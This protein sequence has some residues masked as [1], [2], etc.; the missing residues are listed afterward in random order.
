MTFDAEDMALTDRLRQKYA[1]MVVDR[2]QEERLGQGVDTAAIAAAQ[3]RE[4]QKRL[5]EMKNSRGGAAAVNE[6]AQVKLCQYCQG[7]GR[8]KE[9]Y[10]Y[11]EM[12]RHCEHCDGEGTISRGGPKPK[13]EQP[14]PQT[15]EINANKRYTLQKSIRKL[16]SQLDR[17]R[18]EMDEV[19]AKMHS[20]EVSNQ[21]ERACLEELTNQLQAHMDGLRDRLADKKQALDKL[22]ALGTA[23]A[24]D[25]AADS[26]ADSSI[27][28]GSMHTAASNGAAANGA[29][30]G[31]MVEEVV[32]EPRAATR[33]DPA[34]RPSVAD[35]PTAPATEVKAEEAPQAPVAAE[36]PR[37]AQAE[38]GGALAGLPILAQV[39]DVSLNDLD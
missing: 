32:E 27:L 36:E 37:A 33:D 1:G 13:P 34:G 31:P 4:D 17:Y 30:R 24:P 3:R 25:P 14:K 7:A 16:E 11:R 28:A 22:T 38:G 8:V 10:G 9:F 29:A 15:V 26:M 23:G 2:T 35:D 6:E 18:G 21:E 12:Q 39:A 19:V 20:G 5:E